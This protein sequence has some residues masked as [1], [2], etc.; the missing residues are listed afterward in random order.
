MAELFKDEH[1]KV[2]ELAPEVDHP[3][4]G[5]FR[6]IGIPMKFNKTPGDYSM[7]PAPALGEH[8]EE[9]LR[10]IGYT[11]EKIAALRSQSVI[12]SMN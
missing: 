4:I 9:I 1:V 8:T 5:K 10:E 11:G 2:R 12:S 6:T 7:R 3:V